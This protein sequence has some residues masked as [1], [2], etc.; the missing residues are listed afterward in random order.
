MEWQLATPD[1]VRTEAIETYIE[2]DAIPETAGVSE[3]QISAVEAGIRSSMEAL[4]QP[5]GIDTALWSHFVDDADLPAFRKAIMTSDTKTLTD[6]ATRVAEAVYSG[7]ADSYLMEVLT[8]AGHVVGVVG[9][10]ERP[11]VMTKEGPVELADAL[12]RRL[13]KVK[14]A[15]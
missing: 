6:H 3:E 8:E 9:D 10:E 12:R 13:V 4:V 1:A 14:P 7:R 2:T 5:M 15:Y 11:M